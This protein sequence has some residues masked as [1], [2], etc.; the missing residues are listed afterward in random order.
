MTVHHCAFFDRGGRFIGQYVVECGRRRWAIPDR[1]AV[2]ES[3]FH[4]GTVPRDLPAPETKC[5]WFRRVEIAIPA[6]LRPLVVYV[7]E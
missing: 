3:V 1:S 5:L 7:E 4:D 2:E 6:L